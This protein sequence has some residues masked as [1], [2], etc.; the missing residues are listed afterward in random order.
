V[1]ARTVAGLLSSAVCGFSDLGL[2]RTVTRR[3][4][5]TILNAK[6]G[7]IGGQENIS[8]L[9]VD[10]FMGIYEAD[11][12]IKTVSHL[13]VM[14]TYRRPRAFRPYFNVCNSL[15]T[16]RNPFLS[17][18]RR[19]LFSWGDEQLRFDAGF[20][21]VRCGWNCNHKS[22][23][24]MNQRL[25]GHDYFNFIICFVA[26]VRLSEAAPGG[27]NLR[28][29]TFSQAMLIRDLVYEFGR[30]LLR[31]SHA[32][33]HNC[34]ERYVHVFAIPGINALRGTQSATQFV[35]HPIGW[36]G[37]E[38]VGNDAFNL[39]NVILTQSPFMETVDRFRMT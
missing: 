32:Q 4:N 15:A 20:V 39:M 25:S 7:E 36:H 37:Y 10:R 3:D 5:E 17:A 19:H 23:V 8:P 12:Q 18:E 38:K 13:A 28:T 11:S 6:C 35:A 33:S 22:S 30:R 29:V 31:R 2:G 9:D 26:D 14:H 16:A 27:E 34:H 1:E 24:F 21:Q